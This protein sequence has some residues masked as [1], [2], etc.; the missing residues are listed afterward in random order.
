MHYPNTPDADVREL[1]RLIT[2]Y[3]NLSTDQLL[4]Y[5]SNLT[6]E[7]FEKLADRLSKE[8]R[9]YFDKPNHRIKYQKETPEDPAIFAAFWVL[10]DFIKDTS[11][12][13]IGD[14]PASIT[15]FHKNEIYD[16]CFVPVGKEILTNQLFTASCP[17]EQSKK[18]VI[19]E[20]MKQA[21]S[22]TSPNIQAFCLVDSLGNTQYF[23]K[24]RN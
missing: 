2:T 10:L 13:T 22:F 4:K 15:F 12:H 23:K 3:K 16:I 19:L 21:S 7:I 17:Q 20:D 18:L 5:F 6:P 1:V 11:F 24:E 14:V 8:G 9:I